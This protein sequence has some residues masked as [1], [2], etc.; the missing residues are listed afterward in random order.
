MVLIKAETVQLMM[1]SYVDAASVA[2]AL[3]DAS[4]EFWEL[5]PINGLVVFYALKARLE[6]AIF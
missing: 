3:V 1:P 5:P 6:K 2:L 4:S